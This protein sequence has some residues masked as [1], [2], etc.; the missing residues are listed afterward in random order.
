ML[1]VDDFQNYNEPSKMNFRN[2]KV[3]FE[4]IERIVIGF[5]R[6]IMTLQSLM[7]ETMNIHLSGRRSN[8]KIVREMGIE[9]STKI[10]NSKEDLRRSSNKMELQNLIESLIRRLLETVTL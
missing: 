6:I 2:D 3:D 10:L 5:F 4:F 1:Y 8:R 7:E 9:I